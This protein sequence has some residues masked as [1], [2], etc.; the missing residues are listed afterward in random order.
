MQKEE[1]PSGRIQ[2]SVHQRFIQKGWTLSTAESCTG[3]SVAAR[4]TRIPGASKYYMGSIIAYSNEL[5]VKLLDVRPQTLQSHGA[6]SKEAVIEMAKGLL[7]H[8]GTDFGIAV[9][10]IAGPDGGT[11]EKPVGT[12]FAAVIRKGRDPYAWKF[13]CT[14]TRVEIIE[15]T[16]DILLTELLQRAI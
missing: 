4:L 11:P 8:T 10:G 14:G 1:G 7:V 5:K 12:I 3:G 15:N 9:T 2:E 16:V 13:H 6:V